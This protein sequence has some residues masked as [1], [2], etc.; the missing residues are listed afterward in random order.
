[1]AKSANEMDVYL[2]FVVCLKVVNLVALQDKHRKL[3][4]ELLIDIVHQQ[5]TGMAIHLNDVGLGDRRD[6]LLD[7]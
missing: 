7:H 5:S 2:V 3:S 4:K 6:D 1:M